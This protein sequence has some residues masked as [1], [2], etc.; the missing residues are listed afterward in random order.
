M[1]NLLKYIVLSILGILS[2][3]YTYSKQVQA[4]YSISRFYL[5]NGDPYIET[6]FLINGNSLILQKN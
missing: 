1:K 2:T 4:Y 3:T 5:P 6:S